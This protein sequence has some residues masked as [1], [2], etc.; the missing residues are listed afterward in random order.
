MRLSTITAIVSLAL[1]VLSRPSPE[2][3]LPAN[4]SR[5]TI[6]LW[7]K[8]TG[9]DACNI[10]EKVKGCKDI[11]QDCDVDCVCQ[12]WAGCGHSANYW[13]TFEHGTLGE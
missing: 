10:I 6:N 7:E 11:E 12:P 8:W 9:S 2:P 4:M 13:C 5:R 1:P 3:L